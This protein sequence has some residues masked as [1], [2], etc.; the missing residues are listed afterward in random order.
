MERLMY[1]SSFL[2]DRSPRPEID[3]GGARVRNRERKKE[4]KQ[5][6]DRSL[7]KKIHKAAERKI[8]EA[9]KLV[10]KA[11][12]GPEKSVRLFIALTID[13]DLP[14]FDTGVAKSVGAFLKKKKGWK[15]EQVTKQVH[16]MQSDDDPDD[17]EPGWCG[18]YY[19]TYLT[20]SGFRRP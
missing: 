13:R 11:R 14:I 20:V 18:Q 9:L 8:D 2:L 5:K 1:Y 12:T 6:V 19:T 3:G 4:R 15:V 7:R 17:D 16:P 10:K